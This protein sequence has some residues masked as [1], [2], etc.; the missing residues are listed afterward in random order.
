[1]DKSLSRN[2]Y[3][4]KMIDFLKQYKNTFDMAS[5]KQLSLW[6]DEFPEDKPQPLLL[7]CNLDSEENEFYPSYNYKEIHYDKEKMFISGLKGA[8]T[9]AY[10]GCEAVPSVRANMGCGIF[11]TLFGIKQE[12]FEDKMPW[13]QEHLSKDVLAKMGP[14]DLKIGDEFKAGLEHMSYMAERLEGTGCMVYPMDL[15]GVFDTAHIV[16][17]DQIFYDLYDDPEFIH[18]LLNLSCNALIMGMEVCF[19]VLP[20]SEKRI[21][22][23]NSL[24][25]PREKGGIKISEDTS[26]LLSKEHIEEFVAPYT[27]KLLAYFG[28]GYVHYC[29]KNPHLFESVMAEPLAYGLNLGN[30]DMHDMEYIL[31]R[32]AQ[33][34]KIYYGGINKQESESLYD[35]FKKYLSASTSGSKKYLLLQ[36]S[37]S[38]QDREQVIDE[39]LKAN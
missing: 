29:G 25:I 24:V 30:T 16:Y 32:C 27:H 39:W 28:G 13:V 1:M 7:H 19:K 23:Y 35:Y 33:S 38:K 5:E 17:G 36:Y 22:H 10:G 31:K 11:P 26:T 15:Q 37:C 2:E 34:G 18:H 14:E 3:I 4:T 20:D 12:L 6:N 9:A 21:A 8:M